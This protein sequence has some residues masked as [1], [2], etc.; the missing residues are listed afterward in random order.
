M[1]RQHG[2]AHATIQRHVERIG[3]HC[4]L[5]HETLREKARGKLSSEPVIVDGLRSFAGGQY[6]VVEITN[7][8]G[9]GSYYSHDFVVTERRRSGTM[10]KEQRPRRARY[11]KKL[12]RPD[13]QLARRS[14]VPAEPPARGL[15][16]CVP[17]PCFAPGS[18][19]PSM[20]WSRG[21]RMTA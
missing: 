12:G 6:W 3:R 18:V 15:R 10:T 19:P 7:L 4:L 13:P 5:L 2:V 21:S 9:V 11:E 17:R 8:V 14:Q 1:A 20:R 16:P